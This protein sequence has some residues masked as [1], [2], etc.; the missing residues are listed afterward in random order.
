MGIAELIRTVAEL[1]L[2]G[3]GT[4]FLA[5]AAVS[6]IAAPVVQRW[7]S[8]RKRLYYRVQSDSKI[9]LDVPLHDADDGD[10]H[11]DEELIAVAKVVGRLSFV[12]IRIRNTG[13]D[14]E[15]RDLGEP[16]EFTFR[17][18]VIWNAR[19]SDP[20]VPK[21]REEL[22]D[23]L[24]F[25]SDDEPAA[26]VSV[27]LPKVRNELL[28]RWRELLRTTPPADNRPPPPPPPV[29]HGIRLKRTLSLAAKEKFKIVV[30]LREPDSNTSTDRTKGVD[31]PT[32]QRR[33]RDERTVR[34]ARWPL[35]T[36]GVGVLLAGALVAANVLPD[37]AK[38][39]DPA[40]EC[41]RGE[42]DVVG[43]SAFAP[44]MTTVAGRYSRACDG[45]TVRVTATGSI[46]GVRQLAGL[47]PARR[48]TMA[49]MSDGEV[50]EATG[51]LVAQP[52]A[53]VVYTL[54]ANDSVGI[55]GLTVAQVRD[56]YAGRYRDW[57]RLR[58]GPSLPI[59]IVGRGQESGSRRTFEQTVLA[60]TS[61]G[62]LT[63]DSCETA[64]RVPD[65]PVIRCERGTEAQQIDEIASTPG[66]IGYVDLPSA[67]PGLTTLSL[68]GERPSVS[69]ISSGYPFWA[70]EYLYTKGIPPTGSLLATFVDHLR[71]PASG[72]ALTDAGYTP[73]TGRDGQLHLLCQS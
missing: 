60:T 64:D 16:V 52:V 2:S 69:G 72:A 26:H 14:V 13:G 50:G 61:E 29:W 15:L 65:A 73:C 12:V 38:A 31:G 62:G 55:D 8:G 30:V 35:V 21:H 7:I 27:P 23:A 43:S 63:S 45:A 33:I 58:Q 40:V 4:W 59:R 41:V 68:D 49:A 6:L 10:G 51:D 48:A 70:V 53:V 5:L 19:V 28:T 42:V 1:L 44:V 71:G 39:A 25:F 56:I 47:A 57:A 17:G 67:R 9:G 11:A 54:V 66:A 18:R 46:T 24:E 22:V 36:A 37:A 32:G 34:R 3:E 20:S